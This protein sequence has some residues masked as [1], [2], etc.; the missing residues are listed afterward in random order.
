MNAT[1]L[2]NIKLFF[3]ADK[4]RHKKIIPGEKSCDH[5]T[6]SDNR[7]H[8]VIGNFTSG[9][10]PDVLD[11]EEPEPFAGFPRRTLIGFWVIGNV[12]KFVSLEVFG[13]RRSYLMLLGNAVFLNKTEASTLR[14]IA[15][16]SPPR[17]LRGFVPQIAVETF[18]LSFP[19]ESWE[20]LS[21]RPHSELSTFDSQV[22]PN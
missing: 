11:S 10:R 7:G 12:R 2:R 19:R 16:L 5:Q 1:R 14:L 3:R 13:L 9:L 21:P 20:I 18:L 8:L 22:L 15:L 4:D 17:I 6:P